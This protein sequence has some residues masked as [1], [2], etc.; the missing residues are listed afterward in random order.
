[1]PF[2][3]SSKGLNFCNDF[4]IGIHLAWDHG[5]KYC[6]LNIP[7]AFGKPYFT[8]TDLELCWQIGEKCEAM[9]TRE[10]VIE[11]KI[12]RL[13]G[14]IRELETAQ[15]LATTEGLKISFGAQITAIR[16]Q[17]TSEN[18]KFTA[19]ISSQQ[20]KFSHHVVPLSFPNP[21]DTNLLPNR[22]RPP[23]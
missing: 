23:H 21:I 1:M 6:F 3:E 17:I 12:G 15:R 2:P 5:R 18:N 16:N 19:L 9:A 14:E 7:F 11:E 20:G 10:Q 13:E 22:F 8:F 4:D